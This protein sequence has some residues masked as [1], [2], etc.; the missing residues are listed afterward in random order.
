[1]GAL[2]AYL[3]HTDI[4]QIDLSIIRDSKLGKF[5]QVRAI[6]FLKRKLNTDEIWFPAFNYKFGETGIFNPEIDEIQVGVINNEVRK[7]SQAVRTFTPIFSHVGFGK[8]LKPTIKI[9]YEPFSKESDLHDLLERETEAIF[10]GA[11]LNSFTFIHYIE[12]TNNINYRY[13]K[14][15]KGVIV[16]GQ[17]SYMT[18]LTFKAR[19]ANKTLCYDWAK[20]ENCLNEKKVLTKKNIL[21]INSFTINLSGALEVL[22]YEM[23]KDPYYLL[24]QTTKKWVSTQI[25][26]INRPF[27]ITDFEEFKIDPT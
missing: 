25:E 4:S 9:T 12:E 18:T 13:G 6:N 21:G 15:I 27:I 2:M 26:K 22:T 7:M 16:I 3:L 5:P 20:I 1:L 24:D 11:K 14:N 8:I 19:P 10:F 17:E 23:K